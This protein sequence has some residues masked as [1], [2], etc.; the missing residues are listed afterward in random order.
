MIIQS[1]YLFQNIL[2]SSTYRDMWKLANVTPIFKK[3][4][5]QLVKNYRPISLLLICG[6][7]FENQLLFIVN[8]IHEAFEDSVSLE[9][10]V[11]FL[12]ISKA[13]DIVTHDGLIFKLKQNGITG[14]LLKLFKSYLQNRKQRV[15][16]NGLY[17]DYYVIESGV[18]RG[19]VLGPLL[20]PFMLNFLQVTPCLSL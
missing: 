1:F 18:P 16:L 12:N 2:K 4:D 15:V 3:G 11:V 5:K 17:S 19:S 7:S 14:N 6:K 13:F 8:E 10:R 20:F 9:V